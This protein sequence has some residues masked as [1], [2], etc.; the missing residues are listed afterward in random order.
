MPNYTFTLNGKSITVDAPADMPLLWVLRDKLGITG[1][2]Y[3]CGV[4]VC[5]A[6]TCHLDGAA[7]TPCLM[8]M[9]DVPA[10]AKITTIEGLATG[11]TLH[12]VQRAWIDCD[13]AQC[14]FCQAGQ[15]MAAAALLAQKPAP[16]DDDIDTID[17]VCRCGSY[18][19]IRLAIKK[20]AGG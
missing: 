12:P 16:T 9:R 18:P 6:C 13:V 20:A 8:A 7:F 5:R 4:G 10:N 17:N 19:R 14:G 11:E 15:I 1:P 2:K 3:G